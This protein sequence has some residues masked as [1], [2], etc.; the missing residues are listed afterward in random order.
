[1]LF[2]KVVKG[3]GASLS[4]RLQ[5]TNVLS[6]NLANIDTPGYK[7][8]TLKFQDILTGIIE[9]GGPTDL[10]TTHNQHFNINGRIA[11]G[12]I[13]Y[14]GVTEN[15]KGISPSLD[16]NTVDLDKEM[17]HMAENTIM[18]SASAKMMKKKLSILKYAVQDGGG[19]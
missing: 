17:A 11:G 13:K 14:E 2:D 6:S 15:T 4:L 16:G 18:Y 1:M 7:S 19:F 10:D 8:Q 12:G 5:N 3:L 9:K